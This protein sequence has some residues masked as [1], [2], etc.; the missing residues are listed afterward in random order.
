VLLS[1]SPQLS[2]TELQVLGP[3]RGLA[4]AGCW[5]PGASFRERVG[6]PWPEIAL[7]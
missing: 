3:P 5:R 6:E 2:G 4:S 1:G 7:V